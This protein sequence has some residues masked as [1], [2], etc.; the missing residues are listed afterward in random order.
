M[1]I[2]PTWKDGPASPGSEVPTPE[3]K[4][5]DC[6][7]E[8]LSEQCLTCPVLHNTLLRY[9]SSEQVERLACS[10]HI[11]RCQKNQILFLE[12]GPAEH[13]FALRSGLVK[14]VKPLENGKERIVS[15]LSPGGLFGVECLFE[16]RHAYT[17]VTLRPC[18]ICVASADQFKSLLTTNAEASLG[19]IRFL[20]GE[21]TDLRTQ[22]SRL[23]YKDAR[24][25]MAT[26]LI[27][28]YSSNGSSSAEVGTCHLPISRQ[29]VSEILEM[30]PETVSRTLSAMRR[31]K[32]IETR[33]RRITLL[34]IKELTAIA[35]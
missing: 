33:G 1:K 9:F 13:V 5:P 2:Q 31:A 16:P 30:A 28:L 32:L 35:G 4:N 34:N 8:K 21:I 20:I 15:I 18:E 11:T 14:L 24:K 26:L 7:S 12:G 22:I 25:K 23:S 29:E 17:A 10:F 19:M 27:H 6:R 3:T